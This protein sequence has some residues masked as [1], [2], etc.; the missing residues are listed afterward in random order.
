[1]K[2]FGV[3]ISADL[4]IFVR[5]EMKKIILKYLVDSGRT[6]VVVLSLAALVI[7][8]ASSASRLGQ[9]ERDKAQQV[10]VQAE[11]P[12]IL[13]APPSPEEAAHKMA[14][15]GKPNTQPVALLAAPVLFQPD[16]DKRIDRIPVTLE[17][18][19]NLSRSE[20]EVLSSPV[21]TVALFAP[22]V[23]RQFTLVGAKPSGTS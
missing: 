18:C 5:S 21:S 1:V 19:A 4:R 12:Q 8:G 17:F 6:A 20:T 7:S 10:K 16:N 9:P 15:E 14:T 22:Q 11:D 13:P 2:E 23:G 3:D